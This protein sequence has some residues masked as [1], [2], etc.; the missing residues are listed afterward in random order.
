MKFMERFNNIYVI[1]TKMFGFE[2]YMSAYL[3]KGKEL[4]L[5]DTGEPNQLETVRAGIKVHGFS[6]SDISKIFITHAHQDHAGNVGPLLRES[7]QAKV[8]AHPAAEQRLI[9]P[10]GINWGARFSPEIL[11][12]RK[13]IEPVPPSRIQYLKDGDVF[14][15]GD[16]EKLKII[17]APGHQ[18]SGLVIWE[19]K[20][21]GLFIN[22]L[23]G[24]CFMDAGAQYTLNSLDSDN[25][26]ALETLK[27]LVTLPVN[28]LYLG[29][30]GI[31][32]KPKEVMEK[33]IKNLENLIAIGQKYV[34]ECKPE[35][36]AEKVLEAILPE[37]E[38]LR[39]VRGEELYQYTIKEHVPFQSKLYA[40]YCQERFGGKQH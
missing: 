8:Y 3:I 35:V 37:L 18:P 22:D 14:D 25:I 27:K 4:V 16:G 24:N 21:K 40:K 17:F 26:Q 34:S 10:A 38:K 11:A 15:I 28:V 7:P 1:D 36:I 2:R 23:V 29:H 20:N 33:A 5:I 6:A 39:K 32:D 9:D 12:R 13:D 19:E 31:C 30:Y